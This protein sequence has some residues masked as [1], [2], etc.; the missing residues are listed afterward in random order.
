MSL[1]R[2]WMLAAALFTLAVTALFGLFAMAFVY[3]VEDR[4]FERLLQQE[5]QAQRE[6]HRTHGRWAPT[7]ADF[8][9]VHDSAASLPPEVAQV[10]AQE[11]RRRELAGRD[12]RHY[13]LLALEAPG[14]APW[15][16]AEVSQQLVVRPIRTELLGWLAGWGLV[17]V[18]LALGLGWGLA[19]RVSGPLERLAN[20]VAMAV[21]ATPGSTTAGAL[22]GGP[23]PGGAVQ[24]EVTELARA[25][26]ALLARTHDFIAREQAFT[27]EASHEL[28]T[29]LAVLQLGIQRL[30]AHTDLPAEAQ[31]TLT[32]LYAATQWMQQ[33]VEALLT[34]AR[35]VERGAQ[36]HAPVA[37]LPLL[38]QWV[39]AHAEWL[40]AQA[41]T[42]D[43]Q[44]DRHARLP[45][46]APVLQLVLACL[47][48][49]AFTHG[50]AGGRVS[51]HFDGQA[52]C[53]ENPSRSDE[54]RADEDAPR[55]GHG[56][57]LV[58]VQRLLGA[59]GGQLQFEQAHGHTR[60]RVLA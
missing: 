46:P 14:S 39:L 51:V 54:A 38:E 17:T 36:T 22:P 21:P 6:H 47:L 25:F 15:L 43:L 2:R 29:P 7:R 19:R 37:L 60:A 26:D 58:L 55:N 48:G 24:D 20:R 5:A 59:A 41:L 4:F 42:L 30:Q 33:T 52:L 28:R 56:F 40:D 49:N 12:G 13:H 45:L 11:P 3:T 27:R 1:H 44:L 16:V 34:L 10:L 9:V 32:T 35:E 8:L 18:A 53:I 57:G 23:A 31:A 50:R